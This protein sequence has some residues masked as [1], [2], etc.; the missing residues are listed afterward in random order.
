MFEFDEVGALQAF[1]ALFKDDIDD[2]DV[3]PDT[4]SIFIGDAR[5]GHCSTD[6]LAAVAGGAGWRRLAGREV[7]FGL[8]GDPTAFDS[9]PRLR[10]TSLC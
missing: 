7:A 1:L 4:V 6:V 2:L 10:V 5:V 8:E 3:T 9:I